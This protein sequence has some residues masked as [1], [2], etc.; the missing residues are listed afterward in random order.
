MISR[1]IFSDARPIYSQ[2]LSYE[3]SGKKN[4]PYTSFALFLDV[5]L[6]TGIVLRQF[7]S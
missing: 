4:T 7:M 2:K 3:K 6:F 1:G 5:L